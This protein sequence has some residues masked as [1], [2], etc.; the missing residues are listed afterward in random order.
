MKYHWIDYSAAY[1]PI[2]APWLDAAA[3]KYTGCEDGWDDYFEYWK[4]DSETILGKNF[5]G[6]LIFEDATPVAVLALAFAEGSFTI[7]EFIVTPEKRG[8]GC[9]SAILRELLA[10]GEKI[11]GREIG[12]AQAVIYPRNIASQ[13]AFENAGFRF[14][15]AHPDGDAWYYQYAKA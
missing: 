6:K 5:W 9:G 14:H 3:Q 7:C 2:V 8:Q 10:R 4:N 12:A 1:A 11:L 15:H 13:K